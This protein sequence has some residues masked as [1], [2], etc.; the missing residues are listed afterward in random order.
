MQVDRIYE[1]TCQYPRG[2]DFL[3]IP[4]RDHFQGRHGTHREKTFLV[5]DG[6]RTRDPK[7]QGLSTTPSAKLLMMTHRASLQVCLNSMSSVLLNFEA[8]SGRQGAW[9]CSLRIDNHNRDEGEESLRL[10][11]TP[12]KKRHHN[13]I[14]KRPITH[15]KQA[16]TR[17]AFISRSFLAFY[18][19]KYT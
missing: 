3:G 13:N 10:L 1:W 14:R 2:F 6:I 16:I 15:R 12:N 7:A 19:A 17:V 5:D 9:Y 4:G 8:Q 11:T 18:A